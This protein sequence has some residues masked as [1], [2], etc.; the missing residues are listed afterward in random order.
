MSRFIVYLVCVAFL[1]LVFRGGIE[2]LADRLSGH[3]PEAVPLLDE[4]R[5]Y[6]WVVG[7]VAGI[8]V[9]RLLT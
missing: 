1:T 4:L 5:R 3:L 2:V 9:G 8:A 7:A 6:G